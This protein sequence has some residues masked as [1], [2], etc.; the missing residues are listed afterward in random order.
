MATGRRWAGVRRAR[1]ARPEARTW[2]ANRR[3]RHAVRPAGVASV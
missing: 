2:P 1:Q 3:G